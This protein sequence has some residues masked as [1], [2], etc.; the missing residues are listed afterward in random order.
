MKTRESLH[1]L[2][3]HVD[4]DTAEELLEYAEWLLREQARS[5]ELLTA[6]DE[7]GGC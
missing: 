2:V 6:A 3:D 7:E 1:E 4:E 5:L